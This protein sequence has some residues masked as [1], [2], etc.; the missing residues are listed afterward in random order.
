MKT[1]TRRT[2]LKTGA[3]VASAFPAVIPPRVLGKQAP[4]NKVAMG[5]IG[6]GSQGTKVN[7]KSFLQQDDCRVVAVCDV[8]AKNQA[9]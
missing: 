1:G 2:M 8:K 7:M 9:R 3:A 4:S 6:V 5:F